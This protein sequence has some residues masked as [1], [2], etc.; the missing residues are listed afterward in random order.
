M[1]PQPLG[2]G[3]G[4]IGVVGK[5]RIDLDGDPAVEAA[6][7]VVH[8][9]QHVARVANVGGREFEHRLVERR[10]VSAQLGDL[11]GVGLSVGQS[12]G[13]DRRVRGDA[14]DGVVLDHVGEIAAF[15]PLA[16]EVVQPDGDA[17]F[18]EGGQSFSHGL[19]S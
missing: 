15:D 10:A 2:H 19:G 4:G 17:C 6:G 13:E 18:G 3:R 7:D 1:I 5:A 11:I 16:G 12:A 8:R 14:D 9:A